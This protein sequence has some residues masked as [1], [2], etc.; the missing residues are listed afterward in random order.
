MK[1]SLFWLTF[2]KYCSYSTNFNETHKNKRKLGEIRRNSTKYILRNSVLIGVQGE[3]L[4]KIFLFRRISLISMHL[5][6]TIKQNVPRE[7]DAC[8]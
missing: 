4:R 6:L 8:L 7:R 2:D 1:L 3:F 5:L